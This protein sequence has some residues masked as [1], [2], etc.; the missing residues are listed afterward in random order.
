MDMAMVSQMRDQIFQQEN[1]MKEM[2]E[3]HN[4]REQELRAEIASLQQA[5]E[6]R[7]VSAPAPIDTENSTEDHKARLGELEAELSEWKNKHQTAIASLETSEKQYQSIS[8]E[9]IAALGSIDDIHVEHAKYV[10]SLTKENAASLKEAEDARESQNA[11]V[12][13]LESEIESHKSTISTHLATITGLEASYA[14]AQEQLAHHISAKEANDAN[15]AVYQSRIA[16]LEEEMSGHKALIDSHKSEL[17]N[18][19][20]THTR[21]LADLQA[22]AAAAEAAKAEHESAIAELNAKHEEA[23]TALKAEM[24]GS[25]DDITSL[26]N[27][28]SA[29]LNTQVTPVTVSDHLED[30]IS[31]KQ[32]L[33]G[34]YGYLIDTNEE[35]TKQLEAKASSEEQNKQSPETEARLTELATLVATLE[36]K[37]HEKEQ[38]IKKKDTTIAEIN[39]EK[40]KSVRLVEE[41]EEQITSTFDQ[42]HNR[43]SLMQNERTQALDEANAKVAHLER[44]IDT[45]RVRIEQLEVSGYKLTIFFTLAN[46]YA[47]SA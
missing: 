45:Y 15:S 36:E 2:Q 26:M 24:T 7:P 23:L 27:T 29:V 35:L 44:E 28:I 20:D 40:Q 8:A 19:Q 46:K 17:A 12:A 13:S 11:K 1:Q 42:H 37:L 25:K 34:K 22:K 43:L 47:A 10:D 4:A 14:A 21:E 31:E 3:A 5:L 41:L 9:L 33:E 16:E 39:A 6:A 32:D 30:L 18:L 38:V